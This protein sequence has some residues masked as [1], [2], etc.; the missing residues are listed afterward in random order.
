[1]GHRHVLLPDGEGADEEVR[2]RGEVLHR[3]ALD[4]SEVSTRSRDPRPDQS[5]LTVLSSPEIFTRW[6]SG[7]RSASEAE[8]GVSAAASSGLASEPGEDSASAS[9]RLPCLV[10]V[11]C[12]RSWPGS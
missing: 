4:Q 1:M 3:H 8:S 10:T 5:Q 6:K 2:G 9:A 7:T 12:C 11:L